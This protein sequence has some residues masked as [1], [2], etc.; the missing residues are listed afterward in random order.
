MS[1]LLRYATKRKGCVEILRIL[2]TVLSNLALLSGIFSCFLHEFCVAFGA[3]DGN[4]S[5]SPGDT[6]GL[7]ATGTL[8]IAMLPILQPL[9]EIQIPSVFLITLVGIPGKGAKNRP[10]GKQI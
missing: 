10:A 2:F 1:C 4:F 5:F 3:F 6:D 9:Q 8:V 7:T